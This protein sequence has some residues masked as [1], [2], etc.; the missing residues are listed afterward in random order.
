MYIWRGN[1]CGYRIPLKRKCEKRIKKLNQYD[2]VYSADTD[3]GRDAGILLSYLYNLGRNQ[4]S[5]KGLVDA[6]E[7]IY[8][9]LGD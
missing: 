2:E 8:N 7:R 9:I 4:S 3:A 5:L 6:S 1:N